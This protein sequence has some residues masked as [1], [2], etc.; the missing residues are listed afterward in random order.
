MKGYTDGWLRILM[1]AMGMSKLMD[2]KLT[3]QNFFRE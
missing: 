3:Y 1:V 2:T